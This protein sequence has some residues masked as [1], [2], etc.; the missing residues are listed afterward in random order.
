ML[1][2]IFQ[3][4]CCLPFERTYTKKFFTVYLKFRFNFLVYVPSVAGN[5]LMLQVIRWDI[6]TLN[7]LY[8]NS[9]STGC[10][11][12]YL[13]NLATIGPTARSEMPGFHVC[14]GWYLQLQ[15]CPR[16]IV[17]ASHHAVVLGAGVGARLVIS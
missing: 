16:R 10:S 11:V 15:E 1:S 13:Q 9:H 8:L 14:C 7:I 12:F 4:K 2:A 17:V 5:S 6:F 3:F